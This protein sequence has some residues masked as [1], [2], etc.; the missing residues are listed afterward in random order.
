MPCG[1]LGGP[2]L[3]MI[4]LLIVLLFGASRL[5]EIGKGL[6]SGIRKFKSGLRDE[7]DEDETTKTSKSDKE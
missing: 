1:R 6:G 3:L 4:A 2:E 5:P 7:D